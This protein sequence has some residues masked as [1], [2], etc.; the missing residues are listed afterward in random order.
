[1]FLGDVTQEKRRNETNSQNRQKSDEFRT[2]A[3]SLDPARKD[4]SNVVSSVKE[5]IV[6]NW[7][8]VNV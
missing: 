5:K 4:S 8:E 3:W 7:Q 2:V 1:M 6:K